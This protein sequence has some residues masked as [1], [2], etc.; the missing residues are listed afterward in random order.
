M[1]SGERSSH[2]EPISAFAGSSSGTTDCPASCPASRPRP[3]T[4]ATWATWANSPHACLA[5][6]FILLCPIPCPI[7]ANCNYDCTNP[8]ASGAGSFNHP[9][10]TLHRSGDIPQT[11]CPS[12]TASTPPMAIVPGQRSLCLRSSP[13]MVLPCFEKPSM[14]K[15]GKGYLPTI[16]WES[17]QT[18]MP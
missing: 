15:S 8:G 5:S 1:H 3:A 14:W 17:Y 18:T 11:P 9:R 10:P 2:S 16:S 12:T 4:S 6:T 7:P 13:L